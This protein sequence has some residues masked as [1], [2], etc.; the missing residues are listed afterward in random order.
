M[1]SPDQ[2]SVKYRGSVAWFPRRIAIEL[3]GV[4]ARAPA[5][6]DQVSQSEDF[7]KA[8][9]EAEP[10]VVSRLAG[11]AAERRW[12][13]IFLTKRSPSAGTTTQVQ[14]Q[15]WLEAKGFA[16]PCVYVAP[17]PR[18]RIASA[19]HLDLVI[20]VR[21]DNCVD[22]VSESDA[23]AIL[24]WPGDLNTVP[25]DARRPEI[26]VAQSFGECLDMLAAV[27]DPTP[28]SEGL[29]ALVRRLLGLKEAK[30]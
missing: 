30:A 17:G 22:V 25:A 8:P 12:E 10:N 28:H 11:I 27:D 7:W 26:A 2:H 24:V 14:S 21:P 16:L 5:E 4:L 9:A 19:L 23:R 20:D 6:A 13:L 18:G 15:R 3:D 1:I 29:L